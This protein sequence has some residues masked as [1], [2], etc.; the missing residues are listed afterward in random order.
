MNNA[1]GS[2]HA[3]CRPVSAKGE[4]MLI[5]ENFTS[6]TRLIRLVAP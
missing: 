6:V 4:A 3:P 5:A 2:F 1:G